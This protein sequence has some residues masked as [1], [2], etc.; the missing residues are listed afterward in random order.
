LTLFLQPYENCFRFRSDD[1][2]SSASQ[3][4]KQSGGSLLVELQILG[5]EM[6]E[7]LTE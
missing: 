4:S 5:S 3:L 7:D 2:V 1:I 6:V